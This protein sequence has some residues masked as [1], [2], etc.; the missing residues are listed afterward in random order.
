MKYN[1]VVIGGGPAGMMAA[2]RAA[3]KGSKVILLEKNRK[4]GIKLLLTGKGRCNLAHQD[5]QPR[6]FVKEFGP[7][8]NFLFSAL[9]QFGL[10]EIIDFF[11]K[12]G[13]RL[14]TERGGRIFPQ[15]NSAQ[16]VCR[17]LIKNLKKSG[18]EVKTNSPVKKIVIKKRRIEK[19]ILEDGQEIKANNFLIATG[20]KSYP[21]TGSTGD[22][23][24]WLK[25]MGHR[26][27]KLRPALTPL[28]CA[29]NFLSQLEG[30]S[31]KN[32]EISLYQ[33]NKKIDSRFGEALFTHKG[34][35]GPIILDL[36]SRIGQELEKK[37]DLCLSIDLKPALSFSQLDQRIQ[38]D[39]AKKSNRFFKNSL[40]DL[41]PQKLIPVILQLSQIPLSKKVHSLTKEERKIILHLC[42]E[43]K[44]KI[45]KLDGYQKAIIT[46]GGVDLKEV[47]PLTMQSKII[48]NLYLAGE[49]LDLNG[50]T[51]GY[52]LQVCWATGWV[53]G[54]SVK[55][56][57]KEN[58]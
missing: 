9:H 38:K 55:L 48:D 26:I 15:S 56:D 13:L 29:E 32:V 16:N 44:L 49:I 41:L 43:F 6:D 23:Y 4:L 36:S 53:V 39:F 24:F 57:K 46:A 12:K 51:G 47:N 58:K 27:N 28:I 45:K 7:Q 50:P 20:G 31:L 54:N 11:E 52:N 25:K 1:L 22:G 33:K 19:I 5:N 35:S 2:G 8:G 37:A 42:K 21:Q 34:M 18:V 30:L 40:D 3:A 14:K 10:I 17:V